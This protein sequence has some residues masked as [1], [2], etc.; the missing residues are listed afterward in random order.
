MKKILLLSIIIFWINLCASTLE[1]ISVVELKMISSFPKQGIFFKTLPKIDVDREGCVY[2]VDNRE[3]VVF[4]FNKDGDLLLKF[5]G[6]GQGPGELQW[7]AK[8]AVD[9]KTGEI[10]IKDNT[11]IEI[12]DIKG[13]F[14]R[15][16]RTFTGILNLFACSPRIIVLDPIPG[17]KELVDVFDYQGKLVQSIGQKYDL[18]Y[19]LS[20]EIQ[21]SFLD[22]LAND[23]AVF[24]DDELVYYVSYLFGEIRVFDFSGRVILEKKLSGVDGLDKYREKY[25]K[26]FFQ[27]GLKKNKDGTITQW[28]MINDACLDGNYLYLLL[29][30]Y[31]TGGRYEILAVDKNSL[32]IKKRLILP[33]GLSPE[34]VRVINLNNKINYVISFQDES[35]GNYLIGTLKEEEG[36]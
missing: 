12:F 34:F 29:M 24:S 11:G 20:K 32:E 19:S 4:K 23:G 35:T 36:K 31:V 7:P 25:T 1:K 3:H 22:Q 21:P 8:I 33:E 26:M 17:K 16:I 30:G 5:G 13:N 2:A 6:W 10:L 27:S 15:R 9:R 18:D 14:V 28:R